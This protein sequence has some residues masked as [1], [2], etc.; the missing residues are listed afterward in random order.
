[1]AD[2][3]IS[4]GLVLFGAGGDLSLRMLFPALAWLEH[5]GLLAPSMP[6]VGAARTAM[7]EDAFRRMVRDALDKRAPDTV[8]SGAADRLL[9]RTHYVPVDVTK[10][11]DLKRLGERMAEL[12]VQR[13]LYY[14]SVS[15]SLY[16]AIC[17]G[18]LAAGLTGDGARVVMEKPIGKDLATSR[19]IN[20]QVQAAYSEDRI[21]RIDHYLGKETV[22][23]ILVFR[24]RPPTRRP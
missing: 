23:N 8:A 10:P 24:S 14:L 1:M 11:E 4:D 18:L 3:E 12:K 7:D 15:P 21:F 13:P 16:S 5:E 20:D 9:A 6:I 17:Q 2:P 19:V 22:Q